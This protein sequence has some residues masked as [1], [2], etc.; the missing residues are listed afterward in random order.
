MTEKDNEEYRKLALKLYKAYEKAATTVYGSI[1]RNVTKIPKGKSYGRAFA[2]MFPIISHEA[3]A[4][5]GCIAINNENTILNCQKPL[6][7]QARFCME[8]VADLAYISSRPKGV[9]Q[10]FG[11]QKNYCEA[12]RLYNT[13]ENTPENSKEVADLMRKVGRLG[14]DT[15]QRIEKIFPDLQPMYAMLCYHTHP[16]FIGVV[17]EV[18]EDAAN[19]VIHNLTKAFAYSLTR[20]LDLANQCNFVDCF[21]NLLAEV[22]GIAI[23][24]SKKE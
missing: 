6:Y 17:I 5:L 8:G 11:G 23:E 19:D 13:R 18:Q 24:I 20:L 14:V 21:D 15:T 4:C 3:L 16:N 10:F 22:Y 9:K 2:G 1:E 7:Y 12:T